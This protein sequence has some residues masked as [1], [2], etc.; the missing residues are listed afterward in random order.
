MFLEAAS[1]GRRSAV[2]QCAK[3]GRR[4]ITC[5]PVLWRVSVSWRQGIRVSLR[6]AENE[7]SGTWEEH[8]REWKKKDLRF[9][10]SPPHTHI[11]SYFVETIWPLT[12]IATGKS[13]KPIQAW[14]ISLFPNVP[15]GTS[16]AEDGSC[17][18][19]KCTGQPKWPY[20]SWNSITAVWRFCRI[21]WD[22]KGSWPVL[23]LAKLLLHSYLFMT[24]SDSKLDSRCHSLRKRSSVVL[25]RVGPIFP[26]T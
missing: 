10:F 12:R 14:L 9:F 7:D 3:D 16:E 5:E 23:Q 6:M 15:H 26:A 4:G 2:L 24:K 1:G 25:L 17:Y 11:K 8:E 19:P 20:N 22:P 21:S 13:N 18:S